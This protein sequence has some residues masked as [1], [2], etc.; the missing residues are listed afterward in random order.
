MNIKE[1]YCSIF[2]TG[3][4]TKPYT[5]SIAEALDRVRT[6]KS[7]DLVQQVR[8]EGNDELKKDLKIKLPSVAYSGIFTLGRLDKDLKTHS[9]LIA[10]DFDKVEDV[11]GKK[12]EMFELPYILAT[13][14]S[15]SGNGVKALVYIADNT[16]HKEH[17]D[18][19]LKDFT[20]MDKYCRNDS[21][22]CFESYD[23]K[24]LII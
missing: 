23:P 19:L 12:K 9:G 4:S 14:V 24:F 6:G 21:R 5:L 17:F 16:K 1:T 18:A 10:I 8:E 22:L 2:E 20:T 3:K 7:K 11:S 13:W 15:P